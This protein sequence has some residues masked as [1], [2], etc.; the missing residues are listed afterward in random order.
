MKGH[1]IKVKDQPIICFVDL[2]SQMLDTNVPRLM[3]Y[4]NLL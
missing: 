3:V 4:F 2:G 1:A